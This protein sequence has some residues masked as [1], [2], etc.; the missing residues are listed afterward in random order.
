MR[1]A[2]FFCGQ[3]RTTDFIIENL[4]KNILNDNT[5]VFF[6]FWKYEKDKIYI[7][8]NIENQNQLALE[9]DQSTEI[10]EKDTKPTSI[11]ACF[12]YYQENFD[13]YLNSLIEKLKP[14]KYKIEEQIIFKPNKDFNSNERNYYQRTKSF[15]HSK[16]QALYLIK[17]YEEANN[18]KY[19]NVL[20]CRTNLNIVKEL[21]FNNYKINNEIYGYGSNDYIIDYLYLSN[22]NTLLKIFEHA[23]N[24]HDSI[25][26]IPEKNLARCCNDLNINIIHLDLSDYLYGFRYGVIYSWDYHKYAPKNI[27][28]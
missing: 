10:K 6:H 14:K 24:T 17:E 23:Y 1:T 16:L 8:D 13:Y 2:I 12:N 7:D 22:T 4:Q 15:I 18:F 21:N 19:D 27:T 3:L 28:S 11:V 25:F 20:M 5:D 9:S 26:D